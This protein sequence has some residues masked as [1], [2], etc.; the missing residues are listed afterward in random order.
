MN[1]KRGV[2]GRTLGKKAEQLAPA[3]PPSCV[4]NA[5]QP[6]RELLA[7]AL[8]EARSLGGMHGGTV[9]AIRG[10]NAACACVQCTRI[11]YNVAVLVEI[12]LH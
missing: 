1:V 7:P 4:A 8:N 11:P 5:P 6:N 10:V 12:R 3:P 9:R 2:F